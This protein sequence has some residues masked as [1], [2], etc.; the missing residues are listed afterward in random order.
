MFAVSAD[1]TIELAKAAGLQLLMNQS[2]PST[3]VAEV[4][5]TRLAFQKADAAH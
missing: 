2:A 4:S 5:W 1:E 3:R